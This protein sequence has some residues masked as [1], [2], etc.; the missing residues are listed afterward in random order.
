MRG[1][2]QAFLQ[3]L[4]DLQAGRETE[5]ANHAANQILQVFT[6]KVNAGIAV[7]NYPQLRDMNE[8]FL[9]M[10][11]GFLKVGEGYVAERLRLKAG[12]GMLPEVQ[13]LRRRVEKV[14]EGL[15]HPLERLK[16]KVCITGPYTI[17]SLFHQRDGELLKDLG[18]LLASV[19]SKNLFKEKKMEVSMVSLDEPV[20]AVL[21]DPL[22]DYG[23]QGREELRK[24][25]DRIFSEVKGRGAETVLHLHNTRDGLFWEV[26]S[27]QILESHVGD[28][29]YSSTKAK[30]MAE[31][32]DKFFKAS[33]AL[34]DFDSLI[35]KRLRGEGMEQVG[36]VWRRIKRGEVSPES[37]LEEVEALRVRLRRVVGFLGEE[38]VPYAG[39]ECGL[40]GFPTYPCAVECLRRVAQA[41]E[42]W[43]S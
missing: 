2:L 7:P 24:A 29:L 25:W 36:K 33:I 14:F 30:R 38:R 20:F 41:A 35:M 22:L 13:I 9:E 40:G 12:R 5:Q 31:E 17:S 6:D 37:F 23:S 1:S 21:D 3:G 27:L 18:F 42:A 10:F 28:L 26:E 43:K 39:P 4:E 19:A 11:E 16:V 8:M 15:Q 32:K 34:T